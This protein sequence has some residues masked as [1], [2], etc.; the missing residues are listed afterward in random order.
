MFDYR[1][2]E[3]TLNDDTTARLD[4]SMVE[5]KKTK[6][7]IHVDE[8]VPNVIEP[9]FGIGRILYAVLEHSFRK[10]EEG[11]QNSYFAFSPLIAPQKCSILPLSAK[12]EFSP[13]V[14]QICKHKIIK[15]EYLKSHCWPLFSF[16]PEQLE[17]FA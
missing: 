15:F 14:E 8:F 4:Q 13:F 11:D 17:Y 1:S 6:K 2:I 12:T 3:L 5:V 7:T 16:S 10:R 9:S